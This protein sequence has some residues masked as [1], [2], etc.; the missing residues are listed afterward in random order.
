MSVDRSNGQAS[1]RPLEELLEGFGALSSEYQILLNQHRE[2]ANKLSWAKE[3]YLELS[4]R[5]APDTASQDYRVFLRDL[6]RPGKPQQNG[7]T[8]WLEMLTQSSNEERRTRAHLIRQADATYS[9]LN[10]SRNTHETDGVRPR[11]STVA[12]RPRNSH[13]N[14]A[15]S[16]AQSNLATVMEQD[17]TTPG[18]PSRLG[19]PFAKPN[20]LPCRKL[21]SAGQSQRSNAAL[22]RSSVSRLNLPTGR[23]SQRQ[24]FHDPIRA[25]ICGM[26]AL[27]PE[28]SVEGSTA[29]CPIRFLDQHSPEEVA[30]YFE[31]HKHEI[32]RSHEVCVRR[33]QSNSE[34]IRQLDAK[35]GNLVSMIQGLGAKHQPWLPDKP[36]D[37]DMAEEATS[38][39]KV[40][41]WA[42]QVSS[43]MQNGNLGDVE[44]AVE[45][46]E[47]QPHFD[48]PLKEV[49][50][51][52]SPTR[53]WGI[54]VP[55]KY[56]EAKSD[57]SNHDAP[58]VTPQVEHIAEAAPA[59]EKPAG[60]CPFD[61]TKLRAQIPKATEPPAESRSKETPQQAPAMP[62]FIQQPNTSTGHPESSKP[63]QMIFTGP[64]FIGYPVEQAMALLQQWQSGMKS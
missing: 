10:K 49:R 22:S 52:E 47:R 19:C 50:V 17:F 5:F 34:S 7:H 33:Y 41:K 18:T 25:E 26:D 48:R 13:A 38:K 62:T 61:H 31:K 3:Q 28:E 56:H 8:N 32:P 15:V 36:E 63:A 30:T 12:D 37:E 54:S 39:D 53:P 1:P 27:S 29:V 14:S 55:A 64:V 16:K 2:L 45:D 21:S 24:S 9:K 44:Q 4:R 51:G 42:K 11:N 20:G 43:S 6:D 60:R 58:A 46:E 57:A 59:N 40:Q 35:Y 23:R